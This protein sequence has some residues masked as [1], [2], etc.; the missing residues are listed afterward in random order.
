MNVRMKN[1]RTNAASKV[2][3][4]SLV[5]IHWMGPTNQ[6]SASREDRSSDGGSAVGR[7]VPDL[8]VFWLST[9]SCD[10]IYLKQAAELPDMELGC[11]QVFHYCTRTRDRLVW[12]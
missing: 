11:V 6:P 8:R 7:E 9:F 3:V 2:D 12:Q 10:G 4:M 5:N 1:V